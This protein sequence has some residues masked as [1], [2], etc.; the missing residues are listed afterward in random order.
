MYCKHCGN[1]LDNN[2]S[3]CTYCGQKQ[4]SLEYSV[5]KTQKKT[6]LIVGIVLASIALLVGIIC[7]IIFMNREDETTPPVI[8]SFENSKLYKV[9]TDK[10]LL[11]TDLD[12]L[13]NVLQHRAD[14]F[15]TKAIVLTK[16]EGSDWYIEINIPDAAYS[17]YEEVIRRGDLKFIGGYGTDN[18]EIILT[19]DNLKSASVSSYESPTGIRSFAVNISFDENGTEAFAKGT[20]KY[21]GT[22]ITIIAEGEVISA[23]M[24]QAVI[25]N[26][27]AQITVNS[28]EEAFE[29]TTLLKL[30]HLGCDLE[31][32]K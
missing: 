19:D 11:R 7:L 3:Y 20:E 28:Q 22:P 10:D 4:Q 17:S 29:L 26:G 31:E 12:A 27:M 21:L 30:G 5:Q 23:P 14:N 6:G 25:S 32:I 8:K 15:S 2:T 13:V 18:E 9:V 16:K 24:V 1:K